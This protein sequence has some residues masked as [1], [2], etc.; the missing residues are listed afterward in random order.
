M[1]GRATEAQQLF[2]Q[3]LEAGSNKSSQPVAHAANE[4]AAAGLEPEEEEGSWETGQSEY[5][6]SLH[7]LQ[8]AKSG[9]LPNL[10]QLEAS[11]A[12]QEQSA[13]L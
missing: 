2:R 12:S 13:L 6:M 10:R 9:N 11:V 8:G 4:T 1:Q 5:S 7:A 3:A